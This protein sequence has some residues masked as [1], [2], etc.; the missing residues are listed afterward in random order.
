[1]FVNKHSRF[2]LTC[3]R[4]FINLPTTVWGEFIP[5]IFCCLRKFVAQRCVCL[6]I[7]LIIDEKFRKPSKASGILRQPLGNKAISRNNISFIKISSSEFF[8]ATKH[9]S[10]ISWNSQRSVKVHLVK[11]AIVYVFMFHN[12]KCAKTATAHKKEC[13]EIVVY[14]LLF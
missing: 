4:K 3:F 8:K 2:I 6:T 10:E 7:A 1:M 9:E 12:P 14:G 13:R 5:P 11:Q